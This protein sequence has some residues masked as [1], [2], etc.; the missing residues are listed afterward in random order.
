MHIGMIIIC[1]NTTNSG[2]KGLPCVVHHH[3]WTSSW[4][5]GEDSSIVDPS[6]LELV[7]DSVQSSST[8]HYT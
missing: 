5:F 4:Q 3:R 8:Q 7:G 6:L 1:I 2:N